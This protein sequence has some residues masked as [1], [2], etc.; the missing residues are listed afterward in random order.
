MVKI[1]L[2]VSTFFTFFILI[3]F[4]YETYA[5]D[6]TSPN[7]R[8]IVDNKLLQ[9]HGAILQDGIKIPA[10]SFTTMF[11]AN[12]N[13]IKEIESIAITHNNKVFMPSST[14]IGTT[15]YINPKYIGMIF[16]Y[17]VQFF[18]DINILSINTNGENFNVNNTHNIIPTFNGYTEDDL[19]WLSRII[20]AEARGELFEGMLAVGSVVMNRTDHPSYPNT[21]KEV[22]L[23]RR[24]GIQFSPAA[25]GTI[26]N[27]PSL[28]S[29]IAAVEVLEGKRNA[30]DALFFM[31]PTIAATS[32]I[33]TNRDY[34]FTLQ[35]HSFFY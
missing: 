30:S 6:F 34:A 18:K 8:I 17:N 21:I 14:I 27:E 20:Y 19:D 32:W 23:D 5:N 28:I 33:S 3:S 10:R 24:N 4:V 29:F 1:K 11:G 13:F 26:N 2:L 12:I 9:N 7:L 35:N 25:N 15:S 31:N 22:I 16:G